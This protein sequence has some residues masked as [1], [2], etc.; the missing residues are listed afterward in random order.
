MDDACAGLE[1]GLTA[2]CDSAR[3]PGPPRR[4]GITRKVEPKGEDEVT[5]QP[6]FPGRRRSCARRPERTDAPPHNAKSNK[7]KTTNTKKTKC[8]GGEKR[9]TQKPGSPFS[10]RPD[11]LRRKEKKLP[12]TQ[13]T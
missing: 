13:N 1:G 9:K 11:S 6:G 3:R 4:V 2:F 7:K 10:P 8:L 12:F 5:H